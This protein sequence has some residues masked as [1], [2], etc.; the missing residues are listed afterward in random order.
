MLDTPNL[1][2]HLAP[3]QG[4]SECTPVSMYQLQD[5]GASCEIPIVLCPSWMC[6]NAC[7]QVGEA[8]SVQLG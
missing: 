7:S 2:R 6:K 4:V 1:H 3:S 5:L 8:A